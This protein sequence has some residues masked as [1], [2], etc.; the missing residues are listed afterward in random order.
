MTFFFHNTLPFVITS[1]FPFSKQHPPFNNNLPFLSGDLPFSQHPYFSKRWPS[2]FTATFLSQPATF[3]FRKTLP[4]Y[5][6]PSFFHCKHAK[7]KKGFYLNTSHTVMVAILFLCGWTLPTVLKISSWN[8]KKDSSQICSLYNYF[9]LV[10]CSKF[11]GSWVI[12]PAP[13]TIMVFR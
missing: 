3:L 12:K 5:V 13:N 6:A 4:L 8:L 9:L 1:E 10:H 7:V 11:K 2:F